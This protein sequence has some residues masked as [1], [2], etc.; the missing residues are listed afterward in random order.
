MSQ[1]IEGVEACVFDAYG[2]LFDVA[3]AAGAERSR[4]GER[5]QPLAETWRAK[6]L[7]Y[8][9]LRSLM[10]R[11][12]DFWQV[13]ADALDYA[14]ESLG[15]ADAGLRGRLLD[16]YERLGAFPDAKPALERLRAGGLRLAI[17]SNGA[18]AMLAAAVKSAG[19]TGMLEAVLSVEAA[20]VFKPSPSVYRLGVERLRLPADRM[21]FV[22]ANGWD[23]YAAKAYGYRVAWCNRAGRPP[24]RI[25]E[26]PDAEIRSLAELPELL[27]R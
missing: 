27:G 7:Q 20:R 18:P 13:T 9:W 2:T 5:W 26:R 23:A 8:T 6:Q 21:C 19:M 25:P 10:G 22:S 3:A 14:L 4:L 11:H 1:R 17:L 12:V 24:E 16:L 15:L